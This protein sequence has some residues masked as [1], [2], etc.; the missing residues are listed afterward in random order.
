MKFHADETLR[1][2]QYL[3][4]IHF[5]D[6]GSNVADLSPYSFRSLKIII[7]KTYHAVYQ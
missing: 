2:D 6:I 7:Y 4:K 5:R 1:K 3:K